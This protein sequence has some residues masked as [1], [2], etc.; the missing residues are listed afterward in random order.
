MPIVDPGGP[1]EL[2]PLRRLLYSSIATIASN[3]VFLFEAT[4]KRMTDTTNGTTPEPSQRKSMPAKI[5][6]SMSIGAVAA[7][8]L[9]GPE[10]LP[11]KMDSSISLSEAAF[12][13]LC[14]AWFFGVPTG[15]LL[16]L[17]DRS[18]NVPSAW[19][20]VWSVPGSIFSGANVL[21]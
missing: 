18:K 6:S 10:T 21:V 12:G 19:S 11:G 9:A 5:S 1:E 14:M 17:R 8:L 2:V 16:A 4:E 13:S 7:M 15:L 3:L 20:A